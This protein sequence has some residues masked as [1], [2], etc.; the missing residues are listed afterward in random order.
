[1]GDRT[2]IARIAAR[3][4]RMNRIDRVAPPARMQ[5]RWLLPVLTPLL[6]LSCATTTRRDAVPAALE[7]KADVPGYPQ[8]IRYLPRGAEDVEQFK[9]DF[10]DSLI[11]EE[12]L[13]REQ[14]HTGPL[15]PSAYLA[16]SG[17]GDNGAFGA[18]FLSG[19]TKSGTR[20]KFKLVTGVSTGALMA[21]FAFLGPD[22]DERLKAL[23]TGI[24]MKDVARKRSMLAVLY[25]DAVA[26]NAPLRKLVEKYVTQEML[27]AIAAEHARGRILL[28]G[29][30]NLDARRAVIWNVTKIAASGNPRALRLVQ[31]LLVASAAIPGTFPPVMIDVEAGG[32][33]F[34]EMHVDG[35]TVAQVFS[36]PPA[37][38]LKEFSKEH[39]VD[40]DRT[41]YIIR[42]ARL[43]PEW[44]QVDRRTL[45][46]A[47]RAISSLIQ[48]QGIGDLYRIFTV[49]RRDGVD[50]KLAF[51]P[52]T[53]TMPHKSD[54]DTPYMR[55]LF[56]LGY[57]LAESGYSWYREPPVLLSGEHA[58]PVPAP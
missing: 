58:P 1:M 15:P 39:H 11:R 26:D 46:I 49:T 48:Y 40:R 34:Q 9:A 57:G 13:L 56:E 51:I 22:Y 17:G 21:P 7:E 35:G 14:G 45:P 4:P 6:L 54:F 50:F 2:K 23:Y 25:Q 32:Q 52:P 47:F 31:A 3:H 37:I 55:A 29:T 24:S 8:G 10:L 5:G 28:V 38:Q 18:G 53:F 19:W 30:T 27:V 43:D 20:P 42:N 33:S 12:A 16:I 41:L 44:A 36:Y